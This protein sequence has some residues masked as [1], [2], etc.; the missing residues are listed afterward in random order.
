MRSSTFVILVISATITGT[1]WYDHYDFMRARWVDSLFCSCVCFVSESNVF[2][3]KKTQKCLSLLKAMPPTQSIR[4]FFQFWPRFFS[5]QRDHFYIFCFITRIWCFK[6]GAAI[7][8]YKFEHGQS[9]I[10]L[11]IWNVDIELV[12]QSNQFFFLLC[13]KKRIACEMIFSSNRY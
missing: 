5:H 11:Q 12:I 6:F 9:F 1:V 13:K 7:K 3:K 2:F 10:Y 8:N 4:I